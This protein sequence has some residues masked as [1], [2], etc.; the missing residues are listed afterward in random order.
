MIHTYAIT[1]RTVGKLIAMRITITIP[2]NLI[3]VEVFCIGIIRKIFLGRCSLRTFNRFLTLDHDYF[4][5]SSGNCWTMPSLGLL[6]RRSL[7]AR[8]RSSP[9]EECGKKIRDDGL[10]AA[11]TRQVQFRKG[12]TRYIALLGMEL[13]LSQPDNG[14]S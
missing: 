9:G 7:P 5:N 2:G 4:W 10:R 13:V 6:W 12:I 11:C 3:D 8:S 1:S 14:V